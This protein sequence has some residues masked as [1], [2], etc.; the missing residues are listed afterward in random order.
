MNYGR[1]ERLT[2]LA[3]LASALIP[4]K[5]VGAPSLTSDL[6]AFFGVPGNGVEGSVDLDEASSPGACSTPVRFDSSTLG[7]FVR[8]RFREGPI[9]KSVNMSMER[10]R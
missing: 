9:K 7:G 4:F 1:L 3:E 8:G 2:W 6:E 10:F 5:G